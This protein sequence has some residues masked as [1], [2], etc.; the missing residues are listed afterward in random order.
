MHRCIDFER[1]VRDLGLDCFRRRVEPFEHLYLSLAAWSRSGRIVLAVLHFLG[2]IV[3]IVFL[4]C[5][6]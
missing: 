4:F 3:L 1:E 5:A 6:L 2:M